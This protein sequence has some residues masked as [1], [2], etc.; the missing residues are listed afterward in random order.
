METLTAKPITAKMRL[1]EM[2]DAFII[3]KQRVEVLRM[4]HDNDKGE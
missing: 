3:D 1:A 2:Q 4:M